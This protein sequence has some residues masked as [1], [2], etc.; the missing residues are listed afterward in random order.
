MVTSD[1]DVIGQITVNRGNNTPIS[2]IKAEAVT[3]NA[4]HTTRKHSHFNFLNM[5]IWLCLEGVCLL[6]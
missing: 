1:D 2:E 3:C 6:L 4:T 5:V